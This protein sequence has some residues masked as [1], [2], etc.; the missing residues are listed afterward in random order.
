[1]VILQS[2]LAI[3][4]CAIVP[5]IRYSERGIRNLPEHV[6]K[7]AQMMGSTKW[8]L[9]WQ[10]KMPLA[11]LVLMLGLNQTIMHG[12]VMLVTAALIGTKGLGQIV[13]MG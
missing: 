4:I 11:L 13:F 9:L 5:A 12:I 2:F 7:A 8:Q 10:V 6:I 1:M 3:I